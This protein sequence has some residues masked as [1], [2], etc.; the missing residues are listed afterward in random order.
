[1]NY[2][3][4][5]SYNVC[6]TKLLRV[7]AIDEFGCETSD[8]TSVFATPEPEL[9]LASA[10]VCKNDVLELG[11]SDDYSS[12]IWSNGGRSNQTQFITS[13][14]GDYKLGLSVTDT[15]GCIFSD[16]VDVH[17]DEVPEVTM[18]DTEVCAA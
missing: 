4:I 7:T 12:Y 9:L 3:R 6:Y 17:V 5:T 10:T 13:T 11:V 14:A 16:T 2:F 18:N 1:M 15:K 8:T